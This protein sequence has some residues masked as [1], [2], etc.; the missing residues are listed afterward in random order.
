MLMTS[1]TI[2]QAPHFFSALNSA[3]VVHWLSS[4]LANRFPLIPEFRM[5]RDE[6]SPP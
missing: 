2:L 1:L 6:G 5:L 4:S 3:H